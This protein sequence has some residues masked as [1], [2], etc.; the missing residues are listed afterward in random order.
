M[1]AEEKADTSVLYAQPSSDIVVVRIVGKGS[2]Q[3]SESLVALWEQFGDKEH[4]AR[5][6]LDLEKCST[7]DSTFLGV[8][9][10]ISISQRRIGYGNLVVVNTRE[11]VEKLFKTLGLSYIL[12]I[13]GE[14]APEEDVDGAFLPATAPAFNR[15]E[16]TINMLQAHKTLIDLDSKNKVKFKSV[17]DQLEKSVE[18]QKKKE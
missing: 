1:G 13:R 14:L 10:Q 15:M 6:I 2:F 3:N 8:V 18:Q 12:D 16:K 5:F 17:V 9:A 7:M 11:Q 4:Q